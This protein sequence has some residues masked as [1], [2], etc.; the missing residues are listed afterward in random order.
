MSVRSFMEKMLKTMII[1]LNRKG[2]ERSRMKHN[3]LMVVLMTICSLGS[4]TLYAGRGDA[5]YKAGYV[6]YKSGKNGLF[7]KKC[8]DCEGSG[9]EWWGRCRNCDGSG[10]VCNWNTIIIIGVI[11]LAVL[12]EQQGKKRG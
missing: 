6:A 2:N 7:T 9:S 5:L 4:Q 12:A 10:K 11:V 1:H 8:P 3:V